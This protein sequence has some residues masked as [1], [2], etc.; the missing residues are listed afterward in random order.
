MSSIALYCQINT[1]CHK[2]MFILLANCCVF[3][4]TQILLPKEMTI[5][6][7]SENTTAFQAAF[8]FVCMFVCFLCVFFWGGSQKDH[9]I[10]AVSSD[11]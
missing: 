5:V 11:L 8:A 4:Q 6:E 7:I 3:G 9:G 1:L 2:P 10:V